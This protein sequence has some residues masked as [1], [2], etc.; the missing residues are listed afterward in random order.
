MESRGSA[1]LSLT[2]DAAEFVRFCYKRT[3]R[4]WPELY[5]EMCRVA[6]HASFRGWG[7]AELEEHGVGFGLF[8]TPALAALVIRVLEAEGER[9]PRAPLEI[10]PPAHLLDE[11]PMIPRR[12]PL[13]RVLRGT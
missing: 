5:D 6:S 8:E 4:G 7:A 11:V 2:S 12:R 10:R 3:H 1:D 13:L 9:R